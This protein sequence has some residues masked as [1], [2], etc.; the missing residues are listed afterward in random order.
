MS[1]NDVSSTQAFPMEPRGSVGERERQTLDELRTLDPQLAGLYE[2]GLNLLSTIH[3]PGTVYLVAHAGREI[4][5]G[6]IQRLLREEEIYIPAD[7][8]DDD[9]KNRATIAGILQLPATDRRVDIWFQLVR[10]FASWCHYNEAGPPP[11]SVKTA[12]EQLSSFLFGRIGPYFSTQEQLDAMLQ[13]AAPTEDDVK[14]L[15]THLLRPAQRQYFFN[16]LQN[17][18]WAQPLERAGVFSNPPDLIPTPD[19]NKSLIAPWP[20]GNFL[21]RIAPQAVSLAIS[22]FN[23]IPKTLKNPIV[24]NAVVEA[25]L[26]LEADAACALVD[27]LKDA[28]ESGATHFFAEKIVTITANLALAG[29]AEAFELADHLMWVPPPSEDHDSR[30]AVFNTEW[31]FPRFSHLGTGKFFKTVVPAL[32]S[33]D[34]ERTLKLLLSKIGRINR[35]SDPDEYGLGIWRRADDSNSSRENIPARL[36]T[37]SR[38]VAVRQAQSG[39]AAAVRIMEVLNERPDKIF[40][41]LKYAVLAKIGEHLPEEIDEVIGSDEAINPPYF[42]REIPEIVRNQFKNASPWAQ[43]LFLYGLERG[44][45]ARQVRGRFMDDGSG[46]SLESQIPLIRRQWLRRRLTWFR[47]QIPKELAALAKE[48]DMEGTKPTFQEQE[49]AEVGHYIGGGVSWIAEPSGEAEDFSDRPVEEIVELL[50]SWTPSETEEARAIT[51]KLERSLTQFCAGDPDKALDIAAR[52]MAHPVDPRFIGSV[53]V[54]LRQVGESKSL[55]WAAALKFAAWA[56]KAAC[57][58]VNTDVHSLSWRDIVS[59]TLTLARTAADNDRAPQTAGE[60]MWSTMNVASGCEIV[61]RDS[62]DEPFRKFEDVLSAALNSES[63]RFVESLMSV[64]LWSHR[65]SPP[66]GASG[67]SQTPVQKQLLP[68]LDQ[69]LRQRGRS[70]IAGQAMLGHFIPQIHFLAPTWV[71]A[72]SERLFGGGADNPLLHPIWAAYIT[73]TQT[74]KDVFE[75]LRPWYVVAAQVAA[76]AGTRA[77]KDE[78]EW[79]I[80]RNLVVKVTIEF[81]RGTVSIGDSD[82]LME[83][84]F[85]NVASSDKSQAYWNIF[86]WW[87]DRSEAPPES[88]VQRLADLW[89]WRLSEISTNPDAPDAIAEASGLSWLL[90]TP[91]IPT[92]TLVRLGIPTIKFARGDVE[93]YGVW[94]KLFEMAKIAPD[95]T[96]DGV[97]TIVKHELRAEYVYIPVE[98]V[99]P[100]LR[101][102]LSSGGLEIRRRAQQLIN[103]LGE[104]GYQ[105]FG[106]LLIDSAGQEK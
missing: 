101:V 84:V 12:F 50:R 57:Q 5:R 43:Q 8:F 22:V 27:K 103:K 19:P 85:A 71:L 102:V 61:W 96:F 4:S 58:E 29:K 89:A 80:S 51:S 1:E 49:L 81:L 45:N 39:R 46:E 17:P 34:S 82:H 68:I 35:F 70:A 53:L 9:E 7:Q 64:A 42:L 78:G 44:P 75:A 21:A 100:I 16:R 77:P 47:G 93:I 59:S 3:E 90:K 79:S 38:E 24:W 48:A 87:N 69:I 30:V 72:N 11:E 33:A 28:L 60:L 14:R 86:S 62:H 63:G 83:T 40:R 18:M 41:K 6:L 26:P 36:F 98:D 55:D 66:A 94:D 32:E 25:T 65:S 97:E 99:M 31:M 92:E 105:Q 23:R 88:F 106:E 95:E 74:Y 15:Q 56:I 104:K 13:I 76:E 67:P 54:G 2:Q 20:E 52:I 10:S 91:Y 37:A 73:R